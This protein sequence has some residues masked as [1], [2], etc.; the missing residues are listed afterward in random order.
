MLEG[1]TEEKRKETFK[2]Y[3]K[4]L[5]VLRAKGKESEADP[6]ATPVAIAA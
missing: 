4:E 3:S 6:F 2:E 1:F 5:S